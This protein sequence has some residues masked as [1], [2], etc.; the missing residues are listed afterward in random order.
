MFLFFRQ[1]EPQVLLFLLLFIHVLIN[2]N[3]YT[4]KLLHTWPVEKARNLP[5]QKG[6]K[7]ILKNSPKYKS[8][9]Y[10]KLLIWEDVEWVPQTAHHYWT[11]FLKSISR[12]L[13]YIFLF[14]TEHNPSFILF[15]ICSYILPNPSFDALTKCALVKK[16]SIRMLLIILLNEQFFQN[17]LGSSGP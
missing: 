11:L 16:E 15:L 9:V 7:E 5:F 17:L 8:I 10:N 13:W 4:L 3:L 14:L 12:L 2:C 6:K 1:F